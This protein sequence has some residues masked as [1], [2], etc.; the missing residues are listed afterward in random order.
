MTPVTKPFRLLLPL[1]LTLSTAGCPGEKDSSA[2]PSAPP[3]SQPASRPTGG[4]T[5]RPT[6]W[7]AS[8]TVVEVLQGGQYT[9]VHVDAGQ[10]TLW[11]AAPKFEVAEGDFAAV[12]PGLPMRQHHSPTLERDFPLVYFVEF[13]RVRPKPLNVLTV[14]E[15]VASRAAL[16]KQRVAVRGVVS[17]TSVAILKRNWIHLRAEEGSEKGV[18]VVT[19]LAAPPPVGT[20]LV[21]TG[22]LYLD[23]DL[24]AGYSYETLLEEAILQPVR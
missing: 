21:A 5:S 13:V 15:L 14:P 1:L 7:L 3:A 6:E 4:A 11:A 8:G 20:K 17:D 10:G 24:G 19:T 9:Y 12:P 23:V 16:A 18:V 2:T 22:I